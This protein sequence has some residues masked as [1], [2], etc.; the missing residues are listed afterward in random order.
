MAA[1]MAGIYLTSSGIGITNFLIG[2]FGDKSSATTVRVFAA[3]GPPTGPSGSDGHLSQ[4]RTLDTKSQILGLSGGVDVPVNGYTDVKIDQPNQG[5]AQ[6]LELHGDTNGVCVSS[7]GTTWQDGSK[8]MWVGDWGQACGLDWYYSGQNATDS[9]GPDYHPMCTWFDSD[10]SV[11]KR[12]ANGNNL[13]GS[14]RIGVSQFGPNTGLDG[15]PA[16]TICKQPFMEAWYNNDGTNTIFSKRHNSLIPKEIAPRKIDPR[17]VV[18]HHPAHSAEFICDHPT[19]RGPDF[20]SMKER[21][22]CDMETR[23][24]TDF[25]ESK[26]K[27]DCFDLKTM[28]IVDKN[29]KRSVKQYTDLITWD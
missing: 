20:I 10:G 16:D 5:Q 24:V 27:T 3:I 9:G 12:Q 1:A 2:I 4:I 21:K 14:M 15:K 19:S 8:W 23:K 28:H 26:T 29:N 18:S 22:H 17:A 6:F 11:S 7:V 13:A 25:C